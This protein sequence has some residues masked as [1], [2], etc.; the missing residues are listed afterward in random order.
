MKNIPI[1]IFLLGIFF[2]SCEDVVDVSLDTQAPRLVVEGS[3]DWVKGT[4]GS[5]QT[6]KLS[7]TAPYFDEVVPVVSNATVFITRSDGAVYEFLE[8]PG[9]GA[10]VCT[11]FEP[12]Y[13]AEY[14]LTVIYNGEEFTATERLIPVTDIGTLEQDNEGGFLNDE[15]E[16]RFFYQDDPLADNFY[17]VRFD[18]DLLPY[19]EY[20]VWSDRFIQGNLTDESFSDE[21]LAAGDVL[22]IS[23]FGISETY[24]NYMNRLL[25]V[26][27]GGGPFGTTPAAVRGNVVDPL[28]PDNYALG[29]FRL[30]EL[31]RTA[32]T[33]Q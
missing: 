23:F 12:E 24:Y 31:D 28:N 29:Y 2:V 26:S 8:I 4:D 14:T 33:V 22:G 20:E 16:V 13:F 5:Q 18:T 32:F 19:P 10:Y 25:M 15:I 3:I 9:T 6:I 1:V 27:Q 7:T 30:S 11:N 17:M 21:D